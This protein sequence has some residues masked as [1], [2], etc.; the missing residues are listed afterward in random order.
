ML[1]KN[2]KSIISILGVVLIGQSCT[3]HFE[4][5]NMSP[6]QVNV[7]NPGYLFGETQR[8]K[9]LNYNY[10]WTQARLFGGW[11]Q[12]WANVSMDN[13]R[14]NFYEPDRRIEDELWQH[15]YYN[16]TRRLDRAE[17]ELLRISDGDPDDPQVRTRLAITKIYE[18]MIFERV[19]TFWGDVPVSE[20]GKGMHGVSFPKYDPQSQ[21]YPAL[22]EQ[23]ET[24]IAKLN[25]GDF[26]YGQFD[27]FYGGNSEDW[28]RFGNSILL[29]TGMRM[30]N[31]D[32]SAAQAVVTR[33]MQS[34]LMSTQGHS[35]LLRTVAGNNHNSVAHPVLKEMRAPA[36]KSRPGRHLVDMLIQKDDPRLTYI[37]EPTGQSKQVFAETGDVNDLEY[38]GIPP[39]MT[40]AMYDAMN[41]AR[42]SEVA[43]HIWNNED[44]AVPFHV[45]TFAE[46]LFLQAEAALYGWGAS[47]ADAQVFYEAGIRAAMQMIPYNIPENAINA[48][49][50]AHGTLSGNQAEKLEMIMEQKYVLLWT[51]AYEAYVEWRRTGYPVLDPG[52]R[53][54]NTT[55]GVIPRRAY[56]SLAEMSLNSANFNEA[57][58][59]QGPDHPL[60]RMWIDPE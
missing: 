47:E 3:D 27:H 12:H 49:L 8:Q 57:I 25:Q 40:P 31:A 30:R 9:H 50:A 10:E 51:N 42:K 14:P 44:L 52:T 16:V 36:I 29:R 20:G 4:E 34:P 7:I 55:N 48:Y 21:I 28:R 2:L 11:V 56:Y 46:V 43:Q 58:S 38:R 60:T 32:P 54:D 41:L 13:G 59:R 6:T 5:L 22:V 23:L 26:S 53:T 35:A 17:H 39:N 19:T 37:V 15:I 33:A 24:N 1:K 45:F 18:A